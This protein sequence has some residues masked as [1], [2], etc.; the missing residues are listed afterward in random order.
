MSGRILIADDA[1]TNRIILTTKLAAA[2][3]EVN[4][5]TS[6]TDLLQSARGD[7]PD[8]II[9][10]ERLP[11]ALA[12][13]LCKDLKRMP[14]TAKIPVIVVTATDDP[15]TRVKA[16]EAGA[17]D[18][19]TTPI[20][21]M[22]LLARVRSLLRAHKTAVA[23][24]QRQSTVAELGFAE[25]FAAFETPGRVAIVSG[26]TRLAEIWKGGLEEISCHRIELIAPTEAL[27]L[28][29]TESP[30][31]VIVIADDTDRTWSSLRLLAEIR[32][33]E[34]SRYAAV[35]LVHAPADHDTAVTALD[36]GA[37]DIL[38]KGF[39]PNELAIRVETQLRRKRE[40]DRLRASVDEGLRLS[41]VDPLTGLFN[42]RYALPHAKRIAADSQASGR[43]FAVLLADL[44]K[45]KTVN[46]RY[47]HIAGDKVL[48]EVAKRLKKHV[49]GPDMIARM[50]GE[51][52]MIVL[53]DVDAETAHNAAQRLRKAVME[54]PISLG[55]D[56][57][58]IPITISIGIAMT[59]SNPKKIT[60]LEALI[61]RA[62]QALYRAKARG[63]N[64][65]TLNLSAA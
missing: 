56:K 3:Y 59:G 43:G 35:L 39:S 36:L 60:P 50:G 41:V 31:D 37:N 26:N 6:G 54:H 40:E 24:R 10:H 52:F 62:D 4:A 18:F 14:Q 8:L 49:R 55:E 23:L 27:Q 63:R 22:T 58:A 20:E 5:V 29:D 28:C 32:S 46:D 15:V 48:S 1:A 64:R 19:L 65:V 33:R 16:L 21:E 7:T 61:Q 30:P 25:A 34:H 57:G 44:D 38:A 13:D 53:P 2:R 47:G 51:E 11:D 12:A 42:R 9:L 45:F 17:D